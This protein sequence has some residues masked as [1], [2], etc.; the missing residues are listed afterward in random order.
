MEPEPVIHQEGQFQPR[1]GV[2]FP[3]K[4]EPKKKNI[5]MKVVILAILLLLIGGIAW[6]LLSNDNPFS[7]SSPSPTP[8][9]SISEFPTDIPTPTIATVSKSELQVQV[10]NGTG[11]PGEASFLQKEMEKLGFSKIEAANADTKTATKTEVSFSSRVDDTIKT[12]VAAKL[13]ELYTSV[14]VSDTATA[15]VDI[16]IVT[17][18]RKGQSTTSVKTPTPTVKSIITATPTTKVSPTVTP[19]GGTISPTKTPTPTP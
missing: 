14:D 2:S 12:E 9:V 5:W 7:G 13:Q 4:P 11:V 16:K 19:T 18:P 17:G 6:F 3:G 10:L 1:T 15:G 8:T